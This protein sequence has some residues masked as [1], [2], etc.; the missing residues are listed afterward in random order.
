MV[1]V[2]TALSTVIGLPIGVLLV[3]F[4]PRHLLANRP[5]YQ[6]LSLVVNV[7][8]S[9]PFIILMIALIP[10]TEWVMGTSIGTNAAIV[11][12]VV[13]AAPFYARLAET[14]LREVDPGVIEAAQAMGAST[15]QIVL[16]VLLP[17]ARAGILSGIVITA[18]A[19]VSYSAMAGVIGGGGLGDLAV[20]YGYDRFQTDVMLVTIVVMM[21]LVQVMQGVGDWWVARLSR[22][23]G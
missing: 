3:L 18:V 20:R 9:V 4:S 23:G 5:V 17:E 6:V 16:R 12:L 7:L 2:G 10:F 11:P 14:A 19:L 13:G 8:R 15:W 21:V 22:R 1:L